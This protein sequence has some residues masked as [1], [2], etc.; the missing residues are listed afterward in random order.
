MQWARRLELTNFSPS[1]LPTAGGRA[2]LQPRI[3]KSDLKVA[4]RR[5]CSTGAAARCPRRPAA[6]ARP[7]DGAVL[8][9]NDRPLLEFG[10]TQH[11]QRAAIHL[12]FMEGSQLAKPVISPASCR[13]ASFYPHLSQIPSGWL[14]I[15]SFRNI[16]ATRSAQARR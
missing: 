10:A 6:L 9:H 1:H 8:T 7:C 4:A 16:V 11:G 15:G 14:H 5:Y 13:Q 2:R 3:H 12:L